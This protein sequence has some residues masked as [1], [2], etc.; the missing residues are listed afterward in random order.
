MRIASTTLRL[1]DGVVGLSEQL[2]IRKQSARPDAEHE[3]AAAHVIELRGFRGNHDRI[4]IGNTDDAGAEA[5]IA[6][7]R[8]QRGHEHH[9]RGDRLAGG[10]KMLA[11]PQL[12]KAELVGEQRFFSILSKCFGKRPGR[13]VHRH[14]K[15]SE[16][17]IPPFYPPQRAAAAADLERLTRRS[18]LI[19][20]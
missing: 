15:K 5:Q 19:P 9:G 10:G 7:A 11:Q 18:F 14:H 1:R 16:P 2:E 6:G 20:L 12:G 8:Q 13:W 4:V 17:H 3:T